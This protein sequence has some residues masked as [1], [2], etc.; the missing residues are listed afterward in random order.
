VK[1]NVVLALVVC[2]A[3]LPA[4]GAETKNAPRQLAALTAKKSTTAKANVPA[5]KPATRP[6]APLHTYQ[7]EQDGCCYGTTMGPWY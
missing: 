3:A 1:K 7:L 6:D 4:V 5:A 2:L